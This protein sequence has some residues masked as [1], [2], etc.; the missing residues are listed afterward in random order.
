M[1]DNPLYTL[2]ERALVESFGTVSQ[3]RYISYYYYRRLSI[4]GRWEKV[5]FLLDRFVGD[6]LSDGRAPHWESGILS[7]STV[8]GESTCALLVVLWRRGSRTFRRCHFFSQKCF[9]H[10]KILGSEN[11]VV[12]PKKNKYA[13]ND[14]AILTIVYKNTRR[15]WQSS[16]FE[17]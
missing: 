11:E 3:K 5:E 7:Y 9:R 8:A 17:L 6:Q 12:S 13:I 4:W 16:T 14:A 10:Q 2:L 1:T 15:E